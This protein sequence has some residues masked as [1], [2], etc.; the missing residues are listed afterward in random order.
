[1]R[2]NRLWLVAVLAACAAVATS[3]SGPH[4]FRQATCIDP[5]DDCN[6]S[7]VVVA[8]DIAKPVQLRECVHHCGKGDRRLDP[9]VLAPREKSPDTQYGSIQALTGDRSWVAVE[10]H[11]GTTLGCL[12]LDGHADKSD[13][14][15]VRVSALTRCGDAKSIAATP[16]GT[17]RVQSP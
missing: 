1:M 10:S 9:I 17:V 4:S 14:D 11:N 7:V 13:G 5:T 2:A 15:V 8:N 3:C 16:V 12:V 6:W